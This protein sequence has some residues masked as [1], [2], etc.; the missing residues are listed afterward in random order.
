MGR[1][2]GVGTPLHATHRGADLG[3]V[4]RFI[5]AV[6]Q[7]GYWTNQE[8]AE[9]FRLA[10]ELSGQG[11]GVETATGISDS[12][13]PWFIVYDT[14][15]GDVLVHV[16]RIAGKFVVHDMSG[17]LL[18]EGSDLRRLVNRASGLDG[19]ELAGGGYNNVVVLAAL[20]LVVDFFLNTEKAEAAPDTGSD[21]P[22][23]FAAMAAL[24]LLHDLPP[25]DSQPAEKPGNGDRAHGQW[26]ALPVLGE[27]LILTVGAERPATFHAEQ[28]AM[29]PAQN[30]SALHTPTLPDL[31]I[32]G[33][34]STAQ[35]L[36]GT[37]GNDTLVGGAGN[38]TLRGGDGNDLLLGGAGDDLLIGGTGDD[39]LVG[40]A[41]LD[42]LDGGTG[43]DTLVVD[44]ADIARGG[45][46]TDRFIITD[47]LVSQ[48]VNL[49]QAGGN[50]VFADNVKDFSFAEGDHLSFVVKQWQVTVDIINTGR[51]VLP[52]P[53]TGST[54]KAG[55]GTG[56]GLE[57]AGGADGNGNRI[58][59]G[60]DGD[61]VITSGGNET[62]IS[63]L[64]PES[65]LRPG[66]VAPPVT[67]V[68]LDTD[69][70]GVIDTLVTVRPL[71]LIHI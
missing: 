19:A 2:R 10:E 59:D 32:T 65:G 56:T 14:S 63:L 47:S 35:D 25:P 68:E 55:G 21:V 41:G 58:V 61:F 67:E 24:P 33:T 43:N 37:V 13:D 66:F 15:S 31:L 64:P 28:A 71:S 18:L 70:D 29:P 11:S 69:N 12:G 62:G 39:T 27:S 26:S 42:T 38:D 34:S 5:R 54:E 49:T 53:G 7:T 1:G 51:T 20:A 16:A 3:D 6:T 8:K 30:V 60:G 50:V 36:A 40:G 9:L 52:A 57:I 46:G 48:W 45:S 44:A 4:L 23:E 22:M 17:D